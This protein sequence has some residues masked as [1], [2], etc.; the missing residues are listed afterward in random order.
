MKQV[1]EIVDDD[2]EQKA[3]YGLSASSLVQEGND[4]VI[5]TP[6][7]VPKKRG[8]GRP[9]KN[10]EA[11]RNSNTYTDIV[12]SDKKKN[13]PNSLVKEYEKGYYDN[14]KLLYGA[15]AQTEQVYANIE[16]ELDKYRNNRAY[17]GKNRAMNISQFMSTQVGVISTKINAVRELNSVRNKINDLVMKKEQMLKDTGEDN[18]DK[19]IMDAYYAL[20]NAPRYGLPAFNQQL[21]P[22]TINTGTMISGNQLPSSGIVTAG[23]TNSIKAANSNN[24]I[25]KQFEDY[26]NNLNPI[27]KRMI[28]QNDPNVKT[29]VCYDASTGN[30]WFDVVN[31]QTGMSIP[32][33]QRPAEFLLD[34]MRVDTRNAIAV[35]SNTNMTFPLVILGTR[36]ADEL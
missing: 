16:E 15:I 36:A 4:D 20:V 14:A 3:E 17:G 32:G 5:D 26:Q 12:V 1:I 35:N 13:T 22:T 33:I 27:Q 19:N 2:N 23:T 25:D 9:P 34:D 30:K 10:K 24:P 31:V 18:A 8:P 6:V 28:A 21:S 29:V 7:Q 11:D